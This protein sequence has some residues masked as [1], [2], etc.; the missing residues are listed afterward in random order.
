M[1]I[2]YFGN[3]QSGNGTGTTADP[4]NQAGFDAAKLSFGDTLVVKTGR[5]TTTV[6]QLFALLPTTTNSTRSTRL[7][8]ENS[9]I[10]ATPGTVVAYGSGSSWSYRVVPAS[11][12][13]NLDNTTFG[14]PISGTVKSGYI[15]TSITTSSRVTGSYN[16]NDIA[17]AL[18]ANGG[19]VFNGAKDLIATTAATVSQAAIIEAYTNT[20]SNTYSITDTPGNLAA[21]SDAFLGNAVTVTASIAATAAQANTLAGFTKP[22]VYSISD[23][24]SDVAGTQSGALNEA[25]NITATTEATVSQATT[26][27]SASN[28]GT[29]TYSLSDASANLAGAPVAILS[30][31][32]AIKISGATAAASDL[33]AIDSASTVA[34]NAS[35]VTSLTGTAAEVSTA[36]SANSLGTI[37]GLGNEAV[38]LSGSTNVADANSVDAITSGVIT[39]TIAEGN[40]STLGTLTGTDNAYTVTLTDST[41]AASA[42]NLLDGKTTVAIRAGSVTTITGSTADSLTAHN[43]SGISGLGNGAIMISDNAL[44]AADLNALDGKTSGSIDASC[45]TSLSGA[46]S[47]VKATY[48]SSGISGLGKESVTLSGTTNVADANSVDASTSGADTLNVLY[49]SSGLTFNADAGTDTLNYSADSTTQSISL[50]GISAGSASGSVMNDGTDSFT[51]LEA[52]VGGSGTADSLTATGS[53]K[54]L[55]LSG[56]N[57]GTVDGFSVSGVESINLAGGDDTAALQSGGSLGGYL[58]FGAGNDTLSYAVYTTSVNVSLNG[59]TATAAAASSTTSTQAAALIRESLIPDPASL[60]HQT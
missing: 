48:A 21:S 20:G 8:N 40:L 53:G 54:S 35:F 17:A 39:V 25:V 49:G 31:A 44:A 2:Y 56:A 10:S 13:I 11:G 46:A 57:S 59:A 6:N 28:S 51:G 29:K 5:L 36:Y 22:I 55:V 12:I 58:D 7:G 27:D 18:A 34:I 1:A 47:D 50:S 32:S 30:K 33:N 37:S 24:A 23:T 15:V 26:I 4:W 9:K 16:K 45:V 3:P 19:A 60:Q 14:D 52:I 43:S 41:V 38:T 42:L